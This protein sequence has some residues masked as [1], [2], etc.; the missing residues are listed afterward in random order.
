M[1]SGKMR[2]GQDL[3]YKH[4]FLQA[5]PS[6][7]HHAVQGIQL[8]SMQE[9]RPRGSGSVCVTICVFLRKCQEPTHLRQIPDSLTC[10]YHTAISVC[11][12]C[13]MGVAD[14]GLMHSSAASLHG[15][16]AAGF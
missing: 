11:F 1:G 15:R 2:R 10:C 9:G 3:D 13:S 8:V 14:G 7:W 6:V 4:L 12:P 5:K 16:A